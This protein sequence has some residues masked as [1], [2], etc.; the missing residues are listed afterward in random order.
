MAKKKYYDHPVYASLV[1]AP[2]DWSDS[3]MVQSSL[4]PMRGNPPQIT[5]KEVAV[6]AGV[7]AVMTLVGERVTTPLIWGTFMYTL[8]YAAKSQ[9]WLDQWTK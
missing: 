8:G 7:G 9:G 3:T 5:A 4:V 2:Y 1:P 6:V